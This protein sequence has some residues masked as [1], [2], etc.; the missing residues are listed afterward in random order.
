MTIWTTVL[1][2]LI[3][4]SVAMMLGALCERYR[5]SALL[6]YL[7]AG[8]LLG[9]SA[10]AVLSNQ[11]VVSAMSELGVALLLFTIGLDFS[12]RRVK[13]LGMVVIGGG[14]VQTTVTF[15]VA[16]G[17]CALLGLKIGPAVAVGAMVTMSSTALIVR[18]LVRRAEID[19]I[20][21][22]TALGVTLL[23]DMA[24]IPLVLLVEFF[25]GRAAQEQVFWQLGRTVVIGILLVVA[26]YLVLNKLMPIVLRKAGTMP[27]RDV[28]ILLAVVM[29]LG[30]AYSASSVGLSSALGAFVAGMILAESP[31]SEQIRGDI[32]PLR[33]LFVTLFF[34]AIGTQADP[35]WIYENW[36]MVVA[37]VAMIVFGKAAISCVT[38]LFFRL[39]LGHAAAAA[40]YLS[41][42]GEF[43][44]VLAKIAESH[45]T[46][47]EDLF[48]LIVSATIGTLFLAPFLVALGPH[49]I[50][51]SG[52][53]SAG[54]L[55]TPE[56]LSLSEAP[57]A[58]P[59]EKIMIIGFG[60]AGQRVAEGLLATHRDAMLVVELNSRT[61]ELARG[62]ALRTVIGDAV[63][64]EFLESIRVRDYAFIV[65]TVPDPQTTRQIV[66]QIRALAP[67]AILI[68]RARFHIFRWELALAGAQVIVDEED[69]VGRRL[70]IEVRNR[71]P[72]AVPIE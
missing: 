71:L 28:P 59:I 29:A 27:N 69:Q 21:G 32:S 30:A 63:Q 33:T 45:G 44:F 48:R 26:L 67:N 6:G 31:F 54:T 36:P 35:V 11:A 7:M 49:I 42:V 38:N 61:A 15:L 68:V 22:R 43:S 25:G 56:E 17:V 40:L 20:F 60:P 39:P 16:V 12:W 47:S 70:S 58:D 62:Y 10:F 4:L 19:A 50:R 5:Q 34:S 66:A 1:D 23:H 3:L 41:Q 46:L 24:V 13:S 18:L 2:V 65:V 57:H 9:P 55:V 72:G 37:V 51:L 14:T 8:T 64:P 53:M 52:R